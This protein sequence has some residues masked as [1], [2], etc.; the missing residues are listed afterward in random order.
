MGI[1]APAEY[2]GVG[3]G[4]TAACLTVEEIARVDPSVSQPPHPLPSALAPPRLCVC[5][6]VCAVYRTLTLLQALARH[7]RRCFVFLP[8][9]CVWEGEEVLSRF[10]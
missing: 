8:L 7:E 1:E 10:D 4:F 9:W 5:V 3:L 6:C 2:G